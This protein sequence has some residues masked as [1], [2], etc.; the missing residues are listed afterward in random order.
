[1]ESEWKVCLGVFR[2]EGLMEAEQV[3]VRRGAVDMIAIDIYTP[4]SRRQIARA[5]DI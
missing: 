4:D 5:R 3:I 1:M 2:V